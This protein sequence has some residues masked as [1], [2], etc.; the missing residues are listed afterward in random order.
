MSNRLISIVEDD[1]NNYGLAEQRERTD[2][3]FVTL[4]NHEH[5]DEIIFTSFP[6]FLRGS[7][8][9]KVP[10]LHVES[11]VIRQRRNVR[12]WNPRTRTR[13][14]CLFDVEVSYVGPQFDNE[15]EDDPTAEPAIIRWRTERYRDFTL[16]DTDG[17]LVQTAART[18]HSFMVERALRVISV[19]KTYRGVP[20]WVLDY[21]DGINDSPVRIRGTSVSC[22]KG[23][24][25][26]TDVEIDSNGEFESLSFRL[27]HNPQGWLTPFANKDKYEIIRERDPN[28]KAG[29]GRL[30]ELRVPIIGDDGTPVK[31]DHWLDLNG[32]ALRNKSGT[33]RWPTDAEA[34]KLTTYRPIYVS[35]RNFKVL[36]LG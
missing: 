14:A 17:R 9:P 28:D 5:A 19:T 15:E 25:K 4:E 23:T 20:K 26:M 31:E 8:H 22:A 34:K 7:V 27:I 35:Y 2:Y 6:Q 18:M 33:L 10:P 16:Y 29:K 12:R 13:T 3:Y 32:R 30:I 1:Q 11:V 24:L 36:P 21:E